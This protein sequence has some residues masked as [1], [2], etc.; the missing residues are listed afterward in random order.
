MTGPDERTHNRRLAWLLAGTLA[1][2]VYAGVVAWTGGFDGRLGGIRLRSRD[3]ARPAA[4]AAFGAAWLV[5]ATRRPLAVHSVRT[6]HHADSI[7]GSRVLVGAAAA[8]TLAAA[9]IFGTFAIGGADSYGYAGQARLLRHGRLTD[10]IPLKPAFRWP[11]ARATLI[12]LGF[13]AGREPAVIAPLYP[14][15]LPLLMA[16][17]GLVSERAIY[18][19][20]PLFGV[21]AVWCTYRL[22]VDLGQ[23]L[24]GGIAALVL[25]VS[26][27]FLYQLVQPMSDIPAAACWLGALIA[28]SRRT[29]VSAGGAGVLAAVAIAIRPNLAPL[30]ALILLQVVSGAG[31]TRWHRVA[32]FALGVAPAVVALGWIQHVRYGSAFAS[33]YGRIEDGFT[34]ANVLPNLARY[35]KWLTETHT[36]FIWLSAL[37]P[38]W[39]LASGR[40]G[41]PLLAWTAVTLALAVWGAYL[42]YVYFQ[43]QEWFYTRFLLPAIAIMLLFASVITLSALRRVPA[44]LRLPIAVLFFAMLIAACV[45]TARSRQVFGLHDYERKYPDAGAFASEHLPADAFVLAGQHSGSVRYYANRPTLRWDVLGAAHLDEALADLRAEGYQPFAVLDAEEDEQFRAKFGGAGQ[46][47]VAGLTPLAVL[48]VVRVYSFDH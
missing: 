2:A 37:S 36:P 27:T 9:L 29:T 31:A 4:A 35:P 1:T 47:E 30:A 42:P 7:T 24:A 46:R 33:G 40:H 22:G 48:G 25:S 45:V 13:T 17:V 6:W 14:P 26:P 21:L 3:W 12:P 5:Y 43:P 18:L 41:R 11:D 34:R 8:W 16:A 20:V 23:P 15:G 32:A 44:A 38:L 28:A 10:R 39:I 19:V